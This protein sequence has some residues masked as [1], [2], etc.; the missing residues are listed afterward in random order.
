MAWGAAREQRVKE[1][2]VEGVDFLVVAEEGGAHGL[3]L[4]G[5]GVMQPCVVARVDFGG[6]LVGRV[7]GAIVAQ[8][9]VVVAQLAQG[10]FG[11]GR[12]V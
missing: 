1:G 8:E 7:R 3:H 9:K 4:E 6:N 11:R 10:R 2:L 12:R 5:R